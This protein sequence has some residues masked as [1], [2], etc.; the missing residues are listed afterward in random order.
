MLK[1]QRELEKFNL[2]HLVAYNAPLAPLTT[3]RVGGPAD[4]LAR[5]RSAQEVAD[6]VRWSRHREVPL[7]ILGGGANVVISDRGIRGLVIHT[8]G[9]Q[10]L[11]R[12]GTLLTVGAGTPISDASAY[13]ADHDMEGLSFIYAMPGSTGG[14]IWMNARCYDGEIAPVLEET[15]YVN[16]GEPELGS[17]GVYRTDLKDFDYKVSPFQDGRR[18]IVE[19]TFRLTPGDRTE[20]YRQMKE[21]EEDRRRK[22]H[23]LAPCAGSVFK[24]NRAFGAPSGQI[25]DRVGLRGTRIGGARVSDRHGN[26]IINTGNAT[27]REIRDLAET[28]QNKVEQ[29][30]GFTLEPEI[31]F[32][33]EW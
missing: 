6:L 15:R 17:I 21:H 22:G 8:G 31:L 11:N 14:A 33:G 7:T 24:N 16:L 18:I 2:D 1:L 19:A 13:A 32:L 3:F 4:A 27:A 28:V 23:F 10:G 25:I 9:L 30:T 5:P 12:S 29:H 26:I 20:L